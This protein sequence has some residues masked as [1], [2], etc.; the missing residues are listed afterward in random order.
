MVA[1]FFSTLLC[2]RHF[3]NHFKK[4]LPLFCELNFII[5]ISETFVYNGTK[6][7]PKYSS[8]I[9]VEGNRIKWWHSYSMHKKGKHVCNK[10]IG[11]I[12]MGKNIK[13]ERQNSP[14]SS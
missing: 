1:S 5:R 3:K 8:F 7:T 9:V 6:Q 10:K 11:A 12:L 14:N 4:H 13:E 2:F